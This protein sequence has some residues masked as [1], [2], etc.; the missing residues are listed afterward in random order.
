MI[1]ASPSH[2]PSYPNT[3][4]STVIEH[5]HPD[6]PLDPSRWH[7]RR[8]PRHSSYTFCEILS[9]RILVLDLFVPPGFE[10]PGKE[11]QVV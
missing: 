8:R 7:R 11:V 1:L 9:L 3:P 6:I 5:G 4:S 2:N 10:A